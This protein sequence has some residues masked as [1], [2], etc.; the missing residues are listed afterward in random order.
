MVFEWKND[1]EVIGNHM[2]L[3]NKFRPDRTFERRKTRLVAQGFYHK[4]SIHF[5]ETFAPV[6]RIGWIR[7]IM[8]IAVRLKMKIH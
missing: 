5:N 8:T 6:A 3:R 4:P 7:L 1:Y 2:V